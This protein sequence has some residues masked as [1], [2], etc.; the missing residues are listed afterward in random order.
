MELKMSNFDPR[1]FRNAL[2]SFATGVT[3]VTTLNDEQAPVGITASS[4]N[5]VSLDPPL[6]LWSLGKKS[7]ALASFQKS[8]HFAIHILCNRQAELSNQ[9]SRSGTDKFAGVN[10]E[11][12]QLG[13]PLLPACMARF[14]C[15]TQHQ[16]EGGDHII[17]VGE[18][19]AFESA[20]RS[21][22]LFHAGSY[23]D[24]RPKP[25][26]IE[27]EDVVNT[28]T[29]RIS[30]SF[31]SFLLARAHFQMAYQAQ[32]IMQTREMNEKHMFILGA[33]SMN[34]GLSLAQINEKLNFMKHSVEQMDLNE[35]QQTGHISAML[36]SDEYILTEAGRKLFVELAS[37]IASLE[38]NVLV[39]FSETEVSDFKI[40]LQKTISAT[41][42]NIPKLW[43]EI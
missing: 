21:P 28:D 29:G 20:P 30:D 18:V 31:F 1:E 41:S 38:R 7:N 27:S 36:N 32:E 42:V 22:L 43:N 24:S 13:S 34:G 12:G 39:H 19:V 8:G 2:G 10:W 35:I 37:S 17:F 6:V 40:L 14:E 3:I 4:F 15:K 16:Y 5:S 25:K 11:Q 33:L 26:Q 23:A 9:F